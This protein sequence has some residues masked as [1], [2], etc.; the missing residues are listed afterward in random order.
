MILLNLL[1]CDG[2][3]LWCAGVVIW[4]VVRPL[5]GSYWR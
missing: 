1:T 3:W 4:L 2:S 5:E